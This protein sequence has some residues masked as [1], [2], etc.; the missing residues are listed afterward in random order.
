MLALGNDIMIRTIVSGKESNLP[1]IPIG[2]I[3]VKIK[4][5]KTVVTEKFNQ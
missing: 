3:L 2:Q 5:I 1:A 4:L